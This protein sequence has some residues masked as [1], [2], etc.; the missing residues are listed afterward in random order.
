MGRLDGKVALITGGA[1]GIG[2]ASARLFVSEGAS[3]IIADIQD[4]KGKNLSSKI[5]SDYIHMDVSIEDDV[6]N[7]VEFTKD[8]YGRLDC[9]FNNAGIGIFYI[10][11][12]LIISNI[13]V[14]D[15][16]VAID[17]NTSD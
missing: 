1:S 14:V 11:T 16:T 6:I 2:E 4:K 5:G 3:V 15:M 7:G 8:R 10:E 12:K 17:F 9:I 13:I